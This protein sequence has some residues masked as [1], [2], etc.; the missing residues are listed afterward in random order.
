VDHPQLDPRLSARLREALRSKYAMIRGMLVMK[1]GRLIASE[2]RGGI[3]AD[4]VVPVYSI[5]KT[6]VGTMVGVAIKEGLIHSVE[7]TLADLLPDYF[8]GAGDRQSSSITIRHLLTQTSGFD[9][10]FSKTG[11]LAWRIGDPKRVLQEKLASPP[12]KVFRY[13]DCN[14][15]LLIH[16]ISRVSR[17]QP[18]DFAAKKIFRPLGVGDRSWSTDENGIPNASFGLSL[19]ADDMTK[20]VSVYGN[21]GNH[22]G[23]E[24]LPREYCRQ[25]I[26]QQSD[27][28]YPGNSPYG[29]MMWTST[30]SH[31]HTFFGL[32]YGGIVAM[33]VP[34]LDVIAVLVSDESSGLDKI[35]IPRRII[36]EV[37]LPS[38]R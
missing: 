26:S 9:F 21:N 17:M 38:V 23:D 37:V 14:P 18:Y 11:A 35:N 10:D 31:L 16:V 32:G 7:E 8:D 15:Q 25:A 5:T 28:G 36:S 29:Y 20:L 2:F 19:S 4:T 24:L 22:N 1:S 27:G 34:E 6:V 33:G 30:E 3:S 13:D 12:G